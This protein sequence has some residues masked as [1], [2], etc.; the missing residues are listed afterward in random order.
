MKRFNLS[1]FCVESN[2][3]ESSLEI[4][5]KPHKKRFSHQS[6]KHQ[7]KITTKKGKQKDLKE[8][9]YNQNFN[10]FILPIK[11]NEEIL[12]NIQVLFQNSWASIHQNIKILHF[13]EIEAL[14]YNLLKSHEKTNILKE[15]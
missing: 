11:N 12:R 2:S 9:N 13:Y 14:Y 10:F 5:K 15:Y 7:F 6:H 4:I 8:T 3:S 1:F